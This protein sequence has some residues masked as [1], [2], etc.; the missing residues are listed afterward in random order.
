VRKKVKLLTLVNLSPPI[1]STQIGW[2]LLP[3]PE[4]EIWRKLEKNEIADPDFLFDCKMQ[5]IMGSL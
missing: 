4:V 1:P 3:K 5:N 2:A